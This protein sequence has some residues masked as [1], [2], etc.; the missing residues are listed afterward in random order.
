MLVL[1]LTLTVDGDSA[2]F[3]NKQR[4]IVGEI[5][6]LKTPKWGGGEQRVGFL[7]PHEIKILREE[8]LSRSEADE[9]ERLRSLLK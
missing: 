6:L 4:E 7:F 2:V 9:L 5:R 1:V 3:L 8:F